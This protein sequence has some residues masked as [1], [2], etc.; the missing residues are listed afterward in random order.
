M[1]LPPA[2]ASLC[3]IPNWVVWRLV[4]REKV[5]GETAWTKPP[6]QARSP[7]RLAS[8][9]DPATWSTYELAAAAARRE[10]LDGE[11]GGVGVVIRKS[12]RGSIDLDKCVAEDGT[13]AESV[14]GI[15]ARARKRGLYIELS[16]S[17]RGLHVWGLSIGDEVHTKWTL[18][19][20]VVVEVFRATNRFMTVTGWQLYRED[21]EEDCVWG[22]IDELIDELLVGRPEGKKANGAANG[23][24]ATRNTPS[25]RFN[26]AVCRMAEQGLDADQIVEQL[27]KYPKRYDE[28]SVKR[29]EAANRLKG[30]VERVLLKWEAKHAGQLAVEWS[31]GRLPKACCAD[32]R[33]AVTALGI[34]CSYD[35]FHGH[36]LVKGAVLGED[37]GELTDNLAAQIRKLMWD[38]FRFDPGKNHLDD[39]LTQ[40]CLSNTFHPILDWWGSLKW[41]G[42]KRVDTLLPHYWGAPDTPL[43]RAIGRKT[44]IAHV[45]RVKQPG[46]KFDQIIVQE[47]VTNA[48]KSTS[49]ETL[50]GA[51]NFS[52]QSILD[53]TDQKQQEM[54]QGHMAQEIADLKGMKHAEVEAVK[55]FASRRI[56]RAR[57]AYGRRRVDQPRTCVIWATTEEIGG[58]YLKADTNRRWWPFRV[59]DIKLHSL[60]RDRDQLWAEAIELEA[61]GESLQLPPELWEVMIAEQ[62]KRR[63]VHPWLF[64][65]E[66]FEGDRYPRRDGWPGWEE[67]VTSDTLL[68]VVLDQK[69]ANATAGMWR[70]VATLMERLG[71][72]KAEHK[73]RVRGRSRPQH[74]YF[75]LHGE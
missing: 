43:N 7:G 57:P 37:E 48:G 74:G 49:I 5:N 19:D 38:Q 33:V 75:R 3:A 32:A 54:L 65:L 39:A 1:A 28:T 2:L 40:L 62:E 13:I 42:K 59:G 30:E 36:L 18:Q 9:A 6:Y 51:E 17:R 8:T 60:R 12:G 52:D 41:D 10:G 26:K 63:E 31:T 56:D 73:V 45:R 70:Q 24:A 23:Q 16:P 34:E 20:G 61:T 25:E 46:V 15:L 66:Q 21:W 72:Q 35:K 50:V 58:N 53:Q 4:E 55:A 44:M 29:Y 14:R 47:G 69:K 71:W 64:T 22:D 67:R 11:N 27:R 68:Y